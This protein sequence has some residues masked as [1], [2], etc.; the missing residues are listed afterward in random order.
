MNV[1]RP[2]NAYLRDRGIQA[3][4]SG[5]HAQRP[6]QDLRLVVPRRALPEVARSRPPDDREGV[7]LP[8]VRR[9]HAITGPAELVG[10]VSVMTSRVHA[11]GADVVLAPAGQRTEPRHAVPE[12]APDL[13]LRRVAGDDVVLD[14]PAL[15]GES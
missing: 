9:V 5:V 10:S 6:E 7:D 13:R 1:P 3:L 8:P 15:L 14:D 2:R 12:L 4:L 11:P